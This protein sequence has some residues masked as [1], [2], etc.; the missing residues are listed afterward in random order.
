MSSDQKPAGYPAPS[1]VSCR[2]NRSMDSPVT[3]KGPELPSSSDQKPAGSPAPSHVSCRSNRS[4]DSPVTFKG[5]DSASSSDQKPAGYPAPSHVSCR[6]NRS[7]DSPVTFKGPDSASRVPLDRSHS[8]PGSGSDPLSSIFSLL[9]TDVVEFV[10]KELI[11]IK[12]TLDP[13]E[14]LLDQREDE[15]EDEEDESMRI[16]RKAFQ[17]IMLQFLRR[18]QQDHLA[19]ILL[20][21]TLPTECQNKLK[22]LLKKRFER[23]VEGDAR[24]KNSSLDQIYT[25][26]FHTEGGTGDVIS[27]H[28][29]RQIESASR[30]QNKHETKIGC[31]NLFKPDF[32]RQEPI[33]SVMTKGIA[34]IGKTVFT[35]KL[36]LDWAKGKVN[37]DMQFMFPIA[38]R[39]LNLLK[40]KKYSLMELLKLLF[41]GTIEKI[42]SGLEEFRVLFI[43][44][45]LDEF[46]LSL[47][48][49]AHEIITDVTQSASVDML[50]TNLIRGNLIPSAQIWITSRPA[51]ANQIPPHYIDRMTEVR[52]F[53]DEQKD[54]YF[55]NRFR[56]EEQASRV[57]S[58][59]KTSRSI[60]IMCHI[61]I[62]C[63][64]TAKVLE[65]TRE[66]R[67][68]PKTLTEMYIYFLEVHFKLKNLKHNGQSAA[69]PTWSPESSSMIMSLGKLAFEHLQKDN[70]IFYQSDLMEC[71]IDIKEASVSSG[72]LTEI[73][74]EEPLSFQGTVFCFIHLS[75]Q[76]FLAALYVHLMFF[77]SNVNLLAG[78]K[79]VSLWRNRFHS[80]SVFYESAVEMA[81]KNPKGHLDLFLRFLLGL[82]I[83]DNQNILQG[84]VPQGGTL[85]TQ[86]IVAYI[87]TKIDEGL[88]QERSINLFHCLNELKD[89]ST[90]EEIQKFIKSG[91]LDADL[92]TT[93]WSALLFILL[94][95]GADLAEFHLDKYHNSEDTLLRLLP[96][97][98][99]STEAKMSCCNLSE[100]SCE[101]LGPVLSSHCYSLTKLD[102]SNNNLQDS[103]VKLLCAGLESPHCTLEVLRVSGCLITKKGCSSLA[104]ALRSNPDHLLE[105]DIRYN[106]LGDSGVRLLTARLED[107]TCALN[108]LKADCSA[109]KYLKP[110]LRKYA[111][112]IGL[113]P[114]TANKKLMLSNYNE[115]V[116]VG[117]EKQTCPDSPVRFDYWK[118]V[119]STDGLTGRSYWEVEWKGQVYIA[120]AYKTIKRRGD[121]KDCCL[122]QND[123]SW[124]LSCSDKEYS[125]LHANN[126]TSI[127]KA[128]SDRVGVYLDWPAGIL[129]FYRVSHNKLDHLH[130]LRTTFTEPLYPAFRVGLDP[131]NSSVTL[132]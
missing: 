126:K 90:L 29:V 120:V 105:L 121:G 92:S 39:E 40:D 58:H 3:F 2:S 9:K 59:I 123:K 106:H 65:N 130:T 74:K 108:T 18:R 32:G 36:A 69:A 16:C 56:D 28:E 113:D 12:K 50:M 98:K 64:I 86:E 34:G 95:S 75:V 35:Q 1:H 17:D 80:T 125:F 77:N 11:R 131:P 63:W 43:F 97:V 78:A 10:D 48:F 7:M 89:H 37:Q 49:Q 15:D 116:S 109:S 51:T 38:F 27:E 96:V 112:H 101:V 91:S 129:S 99:V 93:Q 124:S 122:G 55:R 76:E 132:C 114:D 83:P 128:P 5:P 81:L 110:G 127:S 31:E 45:S 111:V 62:F 21:R 4:M 115:T 100:K 44:D 24:G 67:E 54:Q 107:P 23:V 66:G 61:P 30:K 6:S 19:D 71:G 102:L 70:L 119:L 88:S 117:K 42:I 13:S 26:L 60:Y 8:F 94:T 84:L 72:V 82:S 57:L 47:D 53:N 46:R 85:Q 68:L 22:S 79:T 104:S 118:Q 41:P 52:G 20:N 87:K 14:C 33:R 73:F 103:G 25:D